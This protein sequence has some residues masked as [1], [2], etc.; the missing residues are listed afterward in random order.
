MS[1]TIVQAREY[2][3]GNLNFWVFLGLGLVKK[4]RK[5]GREMIN[6]HILDLYEI[7]YGIR[8][9]GEGCFPSLIIYS[10]DARRRYH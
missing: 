4:R 9:R 10:T 8:G 1:V 3:H 6:E 2:S 7:I 5:K